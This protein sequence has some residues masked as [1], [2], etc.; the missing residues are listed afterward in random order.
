MN[1]RLSETKVNTFCGF[2]RPC[3]LGW[4]IGFYLNNPQQNI[5]YT[6]FK[7]IRVYDFWVSILLEYNKIFAYVIWNQVEF[8]EFELYQFND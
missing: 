4:I 1:T 6:Q 7:Y 2:P 3:S 5:L 8:W